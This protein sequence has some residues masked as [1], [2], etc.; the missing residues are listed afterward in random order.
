MK[1][2]QPTNLYVTEWAAEDPHCVARME[3]LVAGFGRDMSEVRVLAVEEIEP[4][5]RERDWADL[6]I[7]Q[8]RV[9]FRGDPDVVFN[10]FRWTDGRQNAWLR[11]RYGLLRDSTG[12]TNQVMHMLYGAAPFYHFESGVKKRE[13]QTC[14][15]NLYDLHSAWGCFHKCQYC[16]RGRVTTMALNVEEFIEHVNQLMAANPWQ[17]V[18]RYDVETDCLVLEPEYG[19]CAAL[20]EHYAALEDRYLILFSKS[21]NVDFVLDL[22]HRGHTIM[23]WTLSTPTVSRHIEVDTATTEQRIAAAR[24]CQ[25]AGYT[26]RFKCKP[27]IPIANWREEATA[28]FEMLFEAVEP[29]NISLEMLFFDSVAE[30]RELFDLDLFDPG[31]IAMMEQ[32]EASGNMTDLGHPMPPAFRQQVYEHYVAEIHRLSPQTRVSLC[33]ETEEMWQRLGPKL[34]MNSRSFACNCGP[35]AVP[36]VRAEQVDTTEDGT[37]VLVPSQAC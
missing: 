30:L 24:K 25:E 4:L 31:F 26:V 17:K 3:R 22:D 35:V 13:R 6:D 20:V 36:G 16:R 12:Y 28:T 11:Q 2:F 15:W 23:L 10:K 32:W 33:A 14:C 37:A 7:R 34:G 21:D 27:I 19:M 8:G 29:D 9:P 18:F 1:Q 5:V